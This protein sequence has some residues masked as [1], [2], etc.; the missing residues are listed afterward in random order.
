MKE[1]FLIKDA[2]CQNLKKELDDA[3]SEIY[4]QEYKRQNDLLDTEKK[5]QLEI[6]S[7]QH[8]VQETIEE[9]NS[10]KNEFHRIYD[11]LKLENH[12]LKDLLSQQ[13]DSPPHSLV[14]VLSHVKKTIA[15]KLGGDSGNHEVLEDSMRKVN[16]YVRNR[17]YS[18]VYLKES[19]KIFWLFLF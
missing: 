6:S 15:R 8:I 14:P 16:K 13:T 2:E 1:L 4:L 7:W 17:I 11:E 9:S 5:A 18:L 3:K 19:T 10:T 12:G